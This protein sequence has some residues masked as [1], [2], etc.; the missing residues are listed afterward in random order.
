M[1]RFVWYLLLVGLLAGAGGARARDGTASVEERIL[2]VL[3]LDDLTER[4]KDRIVDAIRKLIR[5]H[6]AAG[7]PSGGEVEAYQEAVETLARFLKRE[8][9]EERGRLI[10]EALHAMREVDK[11]WISR[12]FER[13]QQG[14]LA[15]TPETL[16]KLE[17]Q[18]AALRR[19]GDLLKEEQEIVVRQKAL[20]ASAERRY[21]EI[22]RLN[23]EGHRLF[24]SIGRPAIQAAIEW[25]VQDLDHALEESVRPAHDR[26]VRLLSLHQR[27]T[28]AQ[29][30]HTPVP[31]VVKEY[32]EY[33]S[34]LRAI[35]RHVGRRGPGDS[36]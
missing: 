29:L 6:R 25:M 20:A 32:R 35:A 28:A 4:E 26:Q 18:I 30:G 21:R 34:K 19:V 36:D 23:Q 22:L 27:V 14:N 2:E 8:T 11:A 1:R 15:D 10:Q 3:P 5:I 9:V 13:A 24:E 31:T 12:A 17:E 16:A 33:A 7:D